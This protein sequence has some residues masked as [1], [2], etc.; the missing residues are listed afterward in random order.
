MF[1]AVDVS[2]LYSDGLIGF[3]LREIGDSRQDL[4]VNALYEQGVIEAP[5]FAMEIGHEDE[6]S[7]IEIGGYDNSDSMVWIE[8]VGS[9]Y[10]WT[11]PMPLVK[12]SETETAMKATEATLDSGTSLTYMPEKDYE[13]ILAF[14]QE[15][16]DCYE[17]EE[18]PGYIFCDCRG[19]SDD[20]FP[21]I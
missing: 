1:E 4:F 14:I 5:I 20:R 15:F 11:V 10:H 12:L 19:A 17:Y 7:W 6:S 16:T 2:G 21:V 18:Y 13:A 9:P 8:M 3:S